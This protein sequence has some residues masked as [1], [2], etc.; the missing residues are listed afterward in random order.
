MISLGTFPA[1]SLAEARNVRAE[2]LS[3]LA[4]GIDPQTVSKSQNINRLRLIVFFQKLPQIGL[5]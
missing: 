1:L 4:R 2:Y 5:P 3:L